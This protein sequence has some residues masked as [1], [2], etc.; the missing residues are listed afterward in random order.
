M[1]RDWST[2]TS[3]RPTSFCRPNDR[4][5]ILDFGLACPPGAEGV[6][7]LGTPHYV[8]PEQ[9]E[10]EMVDGRADLYSLGIM[11]FELLTG[12]RPFPEE[13]PSLLMEAHLTREMPDPRDWVADLPSG[14]CDFIRKATRKK[15]EDRFPRHGRRPW[16]IWSRFPGTWAFRD[17]RGPGRTED[18]EPVS[19]LPG[20]AAA[21]IKQPAGRVHPQAAGDGRPDEGR[22]FQGY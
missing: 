1:T 11:T 10:G 22:G 8:S 18:D 3:S 15:P 5:K 12:V 16:P 17:R 7:G 13:D 21:E 14:I 2:W 4:I 19:V 9:I 20:S 6:C